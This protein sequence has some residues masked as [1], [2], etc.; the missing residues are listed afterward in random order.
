VPQ[1]SSGRIRTRTGLT[2]G[3]LAKR[4]GVGVETVRFYERRGL[5]PKPPRPAKGFRAYP[6]ECVGRLQFI[7]HA[8]M[9]GFTLEEAAALLAL[10]VTAGTNCAAVRSRAAAKL[11]D[12]ETR[13]EHMQRIRGALETLVA[14]CPGRGAVS[15][16]TILEALESSS[17]GIP[18]LPAKRRRSTRKGKHDMKSLEVKIEGMQCEGCASTIQALLAHE[19]GVMSAKVSFAE[20]TASVFYDPAMTDPARVAAAIDKA[21]FRAMGGSSMPGAKTS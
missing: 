17:L 1:P 13:I 14:A 7:R 20:R 19:P 12:V 16:C 21:G 18:A 3:D 8:Q 9:L 15:E 4:V 2:I 11:A 10:R 5:L 6:E